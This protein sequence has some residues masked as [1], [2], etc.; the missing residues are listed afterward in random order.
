MKGIRSN[1]FNPFILFIPVFWYTGVMPEF[2]KHRHSVVLPMAL[3]L[4]LLPMVPSLLGPSARFVQG[5]VLLSPAGVGLVQEGTVPPGQRTL[6]T[7]DDG[8]ILIQ[9]QPQARLR[10]AGRD[11]V[12]SSG[13]ALVYAKGTTLTVSAITGDVFVRE[14]G[15]SVA[16]PAG[17]QWKGSAALAPVTAGA[18][19]WLQARSLAQVA[20]HVRER[21]QRDAA[22]LPTLQGS[23]IAGDPGS[24]LTALVGDVMPQGDTAPALCVALLQSG[25]FGSLA[26]QESCRMQFRELALQSRDAAAF[27]RAILVEGME[28]AVRLHEDGM[29]LREQS[30]RSFLELL[31]DDAG[32]SLPVAPSRTSQPVAVRSTPE[33]APAATNTN[34]LQALQLRLGREGILFTTETT[35]KPAGA[36]VRV[37]NIA[38]AREGGG[39][40]FLDFSVDAALTQASAITEG[41]RTYPNMLPWSDFL[42]WARS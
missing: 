31:A 5:S 19:P 23:L 28:T 30:M 36:V 24:S 12:V 41:G 37:S 15:Q 1:Q 21:A 35:L 34:L 42:A 13:S 3:V 20:L 14:N 16:V 11:V 25:D 32:I 33:S 26:Q 17:F 7:F 4:A 27:T 40:R 29:P 22:K 6:S 9:A 38:I 2:Q 18:R 10:A 39:E 8:G